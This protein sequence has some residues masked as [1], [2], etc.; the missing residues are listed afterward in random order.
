MNRPG[1]EGPS[2][3]PADPATVLADARA[4]LDAAWREEGYTVP[5]TTVYPFQWLWD[6]CFH[7]VTWAV[8]GEGVRARR[9][10]AHLFRTQTPLGF[11][12]H[13]DYE[14]DPTHHAGFWGRE[15]RSSITQP[16]MFG[17]AVAVMARLGVPVDDLL[18]PATRGLQFLLRHRARVDG[19]VALCHPWESG[20]DDCP[21]W[22]HWC[23]GGWD[24]QRWYDVKGE[25]VASVEHADD[26]SPIANPA[27]VVASCG[28][29]ALV[30]FN[31]LELASVTGD[32]VL[33]IDAE[34]LVEVLD[35][36]WDAGLR[37]WVDAGDSAATSGRVRTLDALLPV[38]VSAR[39]EAVDAA[40]G[41]LL[42]RGALGGAC[43]PAGVHRA[44]PTFAP[45]TYWR[46][47]AWPQLTYLAWVAAGRR[48]RP[49]DRT[50]LGAMLV[51]G[52]T[53]SGWAEYWDPDDGTGLGAAPQSWAALAAVV[54]A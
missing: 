26:G 49:A 52:A 39:P 21:R 9:E 44:E 14:H 25:L 27:F 48:D 8:L 29:N 34:A 53:R 17:H 4:V 5:S 6:S 42:D 50:E 2:T 51:R 7:A 22:D 30:A 10:L 20:G 45:R 47:P 13:V 31:A 40:F 15:G 46:G 36:R 35:T 19:L 12:P 1:E 37:T 23:P 33:R 32:D 38:L 3:L 43:G 11:V 41:E 18:E 28:F 24:P 16:P 54:V